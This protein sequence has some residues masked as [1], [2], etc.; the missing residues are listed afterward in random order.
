MAEIPNISGSRLEKTI[1]INGIP[2]KFRSDAATTRIYRLMYGRDVFEDMNTL[3]EVFTSH[4]EGE[5]NKLLPTEGLEVLENIAYCMAK[6]AKPD[7]PEIT[8]W[9]SQFGMFDI[10]EH[11]TDLIGLWGVNMHSRS[12]AKKKRRRRRVK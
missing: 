10:Y 4:A 1:E 9:L 3:M 11:L 2:V 8:E 6:Q 7:I 12:A 5:S